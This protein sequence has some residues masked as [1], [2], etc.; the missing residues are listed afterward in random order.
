MAP[1]PKTRH[2]LIL[3]ALL[4]GE[5]YGLEIAREV[6]RLS[7]GRVRL[8][9]ATL[10]G[11]LEDLLGYGWIEEQ[12]SRAR[13]SASASTPSRA[14]GR[15]WRAARRGG[16]RAAREDRALA[17]PAAR[18][19][20]VSPH[21][22]ARVYRALLRLAPRKLRETHADNGGAVPGA[23]VRGPRPRGSRLGEGIPRPRRRAGAHPAAPKPPRQTKREGLGGQT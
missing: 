6:E 15:R 2:F 7:E 13:A 8:W 23:L 5:A 19:D 10:Y 22:A 12:Q 9:P 17:R 1:T 21:Q 4:A 14:L 16:C 11:A 20:G 18:G 3:V